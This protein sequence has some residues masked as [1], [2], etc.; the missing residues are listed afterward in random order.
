MRTI[1]WLLV[2]TGA[3]F[4]QTPIGETSWLLENGQTKCI[5]GG[6]LHNYKIDDSMWSAID[7]NW[8]IVDDTIARVTAANLVTD[9]NRS[10]QIYTTYR[11][12][13]FAQRLLSLK[14]YRSTDSA[15]FDL[16]ETNWSNPSVD[17]NVV[18]WSNVFPAVDITVSKYGGV[19]QHGIWFKGAFLD[20]AAVIYANR[21]DSAHLYVGN[22]IA[23]EATNCDEPVLGTILKQRVKTWLD[24]HDIELTSQYLMHRADTMEY[25]PIHQR[26]VIQND[27]LYLLELVKLSRL[28][29]AHTLYPDDTLW[30]YAD[31]QL[32]VG[33]QDCDAAELNKINTTTNYENDLYIQATDDDSDEGRATGIFAW[34]EIK[35]SIYGNTV[36]ACTVSLDYAGR[37]GYPD[38]FL[39]GVARHWVESE[40]TFEIAK[41]GTD[42]TTD[43]CQHITDDKWGESFNSP[44]SFDVV[45]TASDGRFYIDMTTFLQHCDGTDTANYQGFLWRPVQNTHKYG[46]LRTSS[47]D[48]GTASE[49]PY[50]VI[51]Y[52][53][54]GGNLYRRR[55]ILIGGQ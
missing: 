9:V 55:K 8:Y 20:S 11:D 37:N 31:F 46:S 53:E 18:R 42:W 3:A 25:V 49:R 12:I 21:P 5:F 45:D 50:V 44:D 10:G 16:E 43:G 36:S 40:V 39:E 52:G 41:T 26:Y 34:W 54:L 2:L 28:V 48:D 29:D 27:K 33:T 17:S 19:V 22:L 51:Y 6:P 24:N 15:W 38:G 13:T 23:I 47:D 14:L 1:I 7:N 30:H 4:G 35:D 32:G